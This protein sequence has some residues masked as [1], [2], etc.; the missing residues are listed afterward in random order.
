M[1]YLILQLGTDRFALSTAEIIEIVPYVI[2]KPVPRSPDYVSGIFN[3][4]GT[5]VPVIDLRAVTTGQSSRAW[6]TTRIVVVEYPLD[7]RSD[8]TRELGLLVEQVSDTR[9]LEENEFED[10]GVSACDTPYLGKIARLADGL[11]QRVH[12]RQLLPDNIRSL[13]FRESA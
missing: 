7:E 8:E 4:R 5:L 6:L 1:L 11:L 10:P 9:K 3:F 13:L 2:L 12:A